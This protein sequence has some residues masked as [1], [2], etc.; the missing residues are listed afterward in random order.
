[1]SGVRIAPS[2]EDDRGMG[3]SIPSSQSNIQLMTIKRQQGHLVQIPVDVQDDSMFAYKRKRRNAGASARFRAR[4][5]E[6]ERED[7]LGSTFRDTNQMDVM[8]R[9]AQTGGKHGARDGWQQQQQSATESAGSAGRHQ[10]RSVSS[11]QFN[12]SGGSVSQAGPM[13]GMHSDKEEPQVHRQSHLSPQQV[14]MFAQQLHHQPQKRKLQTRPPIHD[15]Q[16]ESYNVTSDERPPTP[17]S[18]NKAIHKLPPSKMRTFRS[19]RGGSLTPPLRP[20]S[21]MLHV[22]H[23][24]SA[25]SG[26]AYMPP[27]EAKR[28]PTPPLRPPSALSFM[29]YGTSARSG[30]ASKPP[31]EA[32]RRRRSVAKID[33]VDNNV[34]DED[35]DT[36]DTFTEPAEQSYSQAGPMMTG[37]GHDISRHRQALPQELNLQLPSFSDRRQAPRIISNA[38]PGKRKNRK[39][40]NDGRTVSKSLYSQ[41]SSLPGSHFDYTI[42]EDC[43][44]LSMQRKSMFKAL[45]NDLRSVTE[46]VVRPSPINITHKINSRTMY[47]REPPVGIFPGPTAPAHLIPIAQRPEKPFKYSTTVHQPTNSI[48][49]TQGRQNAQALN[50]RVASPAHSPSPIPGPIYGGPNPDSMPARPNFVFGGQDSESKYSVPFATSGYHNMQSTKVADWPH[51]EHNPASVSTVIS[52]TNTSYPGRQGSLYEQGLQHREGRNYGVEVREPRFSGYFR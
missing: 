1:M 14:H 39:Q 21:A 10:L 36:G 9:T 52:A 41:M 20:P 47:K 50:P 34:S 17:S 48:P 49:I 4:R 51:I 15:G 11:M 31:I 19:H 33:M 24:T 29:G 7:S 46:T 23:E 28:P 32:R 35:H 26:G 3:Y 43:T 16:Q 2:T 22:G 25:R 38:G 12:P 40:E 8:R 45:G 18:S 5:K 27:T 30:G 42:F 37:F 13:M 6:T 44:E